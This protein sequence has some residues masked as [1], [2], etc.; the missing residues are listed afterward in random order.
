MT[1]AGCPHRLAPRG[2]GGPT[3]GQ[4]PMAAS[5][6]AS[7]GQAALCPGRRDTGALA[8]H[9]P[10]TAGRHRT[11]TS[12]TVPRSPSQRRGPLPLGPAFASAHEVNILVSGHGNETARAHGNTCVRREERKGTPRRGCALLTKHRRCPSRWQHVSAPKPLLL[13]LHR[14]PVK[15]HG[16]SETQQPCRARNRRSRGCS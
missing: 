6:Q 13:P 3:A 1:R 12:L 16:S 2:P 9:T 5:G 7:E 8:V 11:A 10:S 14:K 4:G 15:A